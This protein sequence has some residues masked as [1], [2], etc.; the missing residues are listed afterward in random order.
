ME[1]NIRNKWVSLGG[2]STVTDVNENPVLKVKGKIFT[3]TRKKFVRDLEGNDLFIV[4]NKFWFLFHR[5][6]FI[7]TPEK[8]QIGYVRRKIFSFH[9]HY[10]ISSKY[11]EV[12][13]R[14]NILGY[15]YHITLNG[16]EIGHVAR[17]IS[18]RDSYVLE[19]N[20]D[21]DW[22]YFVALVI[23]LDNIVDAMRSDRNSTYYSGN[24]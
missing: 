4:R 13:L 14:G 11:G 2:S 22:K 17:K 24:Q 19:I 15:D 12:V 10:D 6:A 21:V 3:F 23:A 16:Q 9:D 5:Q 7:F 8:E 20:D 1:L 18:L